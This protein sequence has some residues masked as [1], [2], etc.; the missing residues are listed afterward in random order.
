MTFANNRQEKG[1]HLVTIGLKNGGLFDGSW[2]MTGLDVHQFMTLS[3]AAPRLNRHNKNS[4]E[5]NV[6]NNKSVRFV[7]V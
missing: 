3:F 7:N 6:I 5:N 1:G 2:R 4:E